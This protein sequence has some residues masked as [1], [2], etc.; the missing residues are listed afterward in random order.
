MGQKVN[1]NAAR[2]ALTHNWSSRWIASDD[3]RYRQL[4]FDDV[5]IRRFVMERLSSPSLSNQSV[6]T[7]DSGVNSPLLNAA[8]LR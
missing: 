1:P 8:I 5:K 6:I 4:L 3:K 2:L 7:T